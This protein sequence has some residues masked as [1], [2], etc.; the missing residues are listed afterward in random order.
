METDTQLIDSDEMTDDIDV[1]TPTQEL[2]PDAET[3]EVD[4]GIVALVALTASIDENE[5]DSTGSIVEAALTP[6]LK[7]TVGTAFDPGEFTFTSEREFS[8]ES[9][10]L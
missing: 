1:T 4:S 9:T 2:G 10:L 5:Y 3:V 8:F 6:F 7:S